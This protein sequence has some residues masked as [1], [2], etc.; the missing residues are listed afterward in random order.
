MDSD[1]PEGDGGNLSAGQEYKPYDKAVYKAMGHC[2]LGKPHRFLTH[3]IQLRGTGKGEPLYEFFHSFLVFQMPTLERGLAKAGPGQDPDQSDGYYVLGFLSSG[4]VPKEVLANYKVPSADPQQLIYEEIGVTVQ[5][6]LFR[7]QHTKFLS[8]QGVSEALIRA[9]QK[10]SK[11][12][13]GT[14]N[15]PFIKEAFAEACKTIFDNYGQCLPEGKK[16]KFDPVAWAEKTIE[17]CGNDRVQG[18]KNDY[19]RR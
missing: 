4:P 7:Y 12:K 10:V 5:R 16:E 14:H 9:Y 18:S 3:G 8:P 13:T 11:D 17:A 15:E 2:P 1:T 6:D 19:G